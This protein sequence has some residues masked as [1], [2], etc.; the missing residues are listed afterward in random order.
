MIE[1]AV[2]SEGTP[3]TEA[4]R[5]F[6]ADIYLSFRN[7]ELCRCRFILGIC[8]YFYALKAVRTFDVIRTVDSH[9]GEPC[10]CSQSSPRAVM[11]RAIFWSRD[12]CDFD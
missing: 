9:C 1:G 5:L 7:S 3:L 8:Y 6:I 4:A 12:Q 2:L 11:F 10:D